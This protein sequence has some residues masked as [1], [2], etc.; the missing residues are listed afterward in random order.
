MVVNKS[1]TAFVLTLGALLGGTGLITSCSSTSQGNGFVAVEK[2]SE[3]DFNKWKLYVELGVK[4]G[5]NR[6]LEEGVVKK[7]ELTKIADSIDLV[8]TQ[9]ATSVGE[10]LLSKALLN[11]GVSSDEIKLI[12]LIAESEIVNRNGYVYVNTDGIVNLTPRTRDLLMAVSHALRVAGKAP[13]TNAEIK[14]IEKMRTRT[15]AQS[16]R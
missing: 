11:S 12:V 8:L 10:L 6:L 9:P 16:Q 7:D 3:Q 2:L 14:F 13:V 4:I 1:V 15:G 5:A